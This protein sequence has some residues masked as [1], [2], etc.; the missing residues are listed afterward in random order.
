MKLLCIWL[1]SMAVAFS[2]VPKTRADEQGL[3]DRVDRLEEELKELRKQLKEQEKKMCDQNRT[4]AGEEKQLSDLIIKYPSGLLENRYVFGDYWDDGLFLETKN[5][6]FNARIGGSINLDA[7][8]PRTPSALQDYLEATEGKELHESSEVRRARIFLKGTIYENI[9]Y[10]T[11][12][13]F[14]DT[15]GTYYI[16]DM[17]V[18]MMDIPYVGAILIGHAARA[19]GLNPVP[20]ENWLT[21]ME[22][23]PPFGFSIGQ[24]L[25]VAAGNSFIDDHL[26]YAVQVGKTAGIHCSEI[27]QSY[28]LNLR[29]TGTPWYEDGGRAMLHQGLSYTYRGSS[30]QTR[31]AS[32]PSFSEQVPFFI[33]TGIMDTD[34]VNGMAYEAAWCQGPLKLQG[35]YY[36]F[37]ADQKDGPSDTFFQGWYTMACWYLSGEYP[38]A[39]YVTSYGGFDIRCHPR[40]DFSIKEGTWGAFEVAARY[41]WMDLNDDNIRGGILNQATLGFNWYLNPNFRWMWNYVHSRV[42]GIGAADILET[43]FGIDF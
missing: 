9:F 8:W 26:T 36:G 24:L 22:W 2:A 16:H 25:G 18:G 21:F 42:N 29:F 28:N 19:F 20:D 27:G 23:A 5:K 13:D 30:D 1:L 38:G 15:A 41:S 4:L 34:Q 33:D 32:G 37:W 7:R 40:H 10:K 35:E 43:R 14:A 12:I 6:Q 17:F 3:K 39:Q 31:Y 11:Q